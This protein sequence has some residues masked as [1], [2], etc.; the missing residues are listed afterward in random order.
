MPPVSYIGQHVAPVRRAATGCGAPGRAPRLSAGPAAVLPQRPG[1]GAG[2]QRG[3]GDTAVDPALWAAAVR[4]GGSPGR[5]A[6]RSGRRTAPATSRPAHHSIARPNAA[7]KASGRRYASGP[8]PASSGSAATA[9]RP[10]ARAAALFTPLASPARPTS[11]EASTVAVSGATRATM[12]NPRTSSAG[13][14]SAG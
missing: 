5:D 1:T 8:I 11:T 6:A 13:S 4:G 2:L 12:P 10:A 3:D 14:T 9:S 7:S